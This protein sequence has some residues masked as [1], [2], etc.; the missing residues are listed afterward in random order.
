M[1]PYYPSNSV[2]WIQ[3]IMHNHNHKQAMYVSVN[4]KSVI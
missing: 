1:S 3:S 2:C 4:A